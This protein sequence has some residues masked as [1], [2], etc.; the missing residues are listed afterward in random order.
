[1]RAN[2]RLLVT[3][4]YVIAM[5][6]LAAC[7]GGPDVRDVSPPEGSPPPVMK[8]V[9]AALPALADPKRVAAARALAPKLDE[10]FAADLANNDY[11]GLGVA[12]VL[13]GEA[14]YIKGFGYRDLATNAPFDADTLFPIASVTKSFGAMAILKLRDEGRIDLDVPASIY[15]SP[16][17]ELV[18]PTRDSPPITVRQL[19][20]HS[21]GL[22]EDNQWIDV[23][24]DM[25]NADLVA[26]LHSGVSFSRAPAT[27]FEY[28]NIGFAIV[29][30]IIESVSGKPAREYIREQ[31]LG[32]LDMT[33]S[34]WSRSEAPPGN[35]AVGYWGA[36]G[37]RGEDTQKL[38]APTREPA[39][40]D[41]VGGLYSSPRDMA[42]Y[43]AYHLSAWPARDDPEAGP[44]KRSTLREMHEGT[45]RGNFTEFGLVERQPIPYADASDPFSLNTFSYGNGLFAQSSCGDELVVDHSGGLPGYVS[46][47]VMIPARGFGMVL[48]VND[49]RAAFAAQATA[50]KLFRKAGLLEKRGILPTP[51]LLSAH[52]TVDRLLSTWS[53]DDATKLFEPTWFVYQPV[54]GL[55]EEFAKLATVHGRCEPASALDV[56]NRLRGRWRV[57]CERGA[58]RFAAALSP[59]ATPRLQYLMWASELPASPAMH[60]AATAI[61]SLAAHWSDAAAVKL[62]ASKPDRD[63]AA[64]LA[65]DGGA[66]SL[67]ET[68]DGDG[69]NTSVFALNCAKQR[70]E[71]EITLDDD[72]RVSNWRAYP[73]RSPES[74]FCA[75]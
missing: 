44:V 33:A 40:L 46:N 28:S 72:K 23:Q 45:R 61:F 36:D 12:I 1:M 47:L 48:M 55:R 17:T 39:V 32:P 9:P 10:I 59:R 8:F 22:P 66:C 65:L 15:Y 20:E 63:A 50:L 37:Y 52:A 70:L 56:V 49:S 13:D 25:S 18:Y 62:F 34:V 5:T 11:P 24:L 4:V 14:V 54:D 30:K 67:G 3:R 35:I 60:A 58:I 64:R 75:R 31:I 69:T 53:D 19:L 73:P 2:R 43:V 16:L 7:S 38:L 71:L 29:G 21:S 51:E 57:T 41:V 26:L 42:R 68:L 27:H 6:A 74:Q